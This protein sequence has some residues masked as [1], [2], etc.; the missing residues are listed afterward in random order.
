MDNTY[1]LIADRHRARCFERRADAQTLVELADFVLPH[2][3]LSGAAGKGHGRTAH[4]GTQFE[5]QTA[6][7]EK[8]CAEFAQHLARYINTEVA[9]HRCHS[10]I[11][12]ATSPMLGELKTHL[13]TNTLRMLT[14]TVAKDLT[15]FTGAE[16]DERIKLAL[17]IPAQ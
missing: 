16:L 1:I 15:H 12:I 13:H 10:L 9:E 3:P 7:S 11:L 2:V 14:R 5:P 8:E 4:A 6:Y 17:E